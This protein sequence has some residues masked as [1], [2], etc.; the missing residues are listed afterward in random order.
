MLINELT[1]LVSLVLFF[2][3]NVVLT[4]LGTVL[5]GVSSG[6][7]RPIVVNN[8]SNTKNNLSTLFDRMETYYAVINITLLICGGFL[9]QKYGFET[10]PTLLIIVLLIYKIIL[11]LN[12]KTKENYYASN[13]N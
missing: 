2:S 9:Y 6:A 1:L 13:S 3:N 11:I 7:I 4:A 5:L 12:L 8:I 10:I